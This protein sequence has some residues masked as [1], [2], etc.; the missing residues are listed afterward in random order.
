VFFPFRSTFAIEYFQDA[1]GLSLQEA[2]LANSWVFFAAIFATPFFGFVADRFGHRALLLTF[3]TL[4][5]SLTFLLLGTT[6][7][8]LWISTAMMGLSFSVV[9][10]IIWPATAMLV[11]AERLGLA[12]G[13][14]NTV[15]NAA[16]AASNI[17]AGWL[18]DAANAG[19]RNPAGYDAMLWFF[20]IQSLT[21][22]VAVVQLWR[23]ES[24][25]HGHGLESGR[26]AATA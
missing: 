17:F 6:Q 1:K 15:Q 2:G 9:P 18:N 16:L 26:Q 12:L 19:P 22:L 14:I 21:A 5:L 25:P 8:S 10:A 4:L 23:R 24:G 11:D 20:G 7:F 13:L 3:G